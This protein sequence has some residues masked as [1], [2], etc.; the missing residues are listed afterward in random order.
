MRFIEIGGV[1]Y[2]WSEILQRR[3]EQKKKAR[4]PQPT[5]FPL[6]EDSRP[7]TQRDASSR[8]AEPTLLDL[9]PAK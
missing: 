2:S 3:R 1:R 8:F 5:L 6:K 9:I 7:P 4:Q